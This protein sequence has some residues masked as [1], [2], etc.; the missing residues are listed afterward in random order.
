LAD[1]ELLEI[2]AESANPQA[3]QPHLKKCF[4]NIYRLDFGPD[5]KSVDIYGME[6]AE[7]EKVEF[8]GNILRARW[9][10]EDWLRNV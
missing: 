10:V 5:P 8:T 1:D 9:G 7:K 6:S 2:L 4:D 3:V